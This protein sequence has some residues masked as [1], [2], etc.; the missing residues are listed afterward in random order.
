VL[1]ISICAAD[2]NPSECGHGLVN[3]IAAV[4]GVL[5]DARHQHESS[6]DSVAS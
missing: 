3:D 6:R 2:I 5:Y 1:R 4:L